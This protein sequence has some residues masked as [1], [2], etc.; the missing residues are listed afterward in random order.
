MLLACLLL[1]RAQAFTQ[2]P[3]EYAFADKVARSLPDTATNTTA[4][5]AGYI[6]SACSTDIDKVRAAY[7]W[8]TANIIYSA[9]SIHYVIMD[10]DNDERVTYALKRK[11]GICENFSA[12]F[13]DICIR[14]GLKAFSIDGFTRQNG[15]MD[16]IP[17][18][19]CAV[20][21]NGKWFLYDPTWD[22]GYGRDDG[23]KYKRG[24]DFFKKD[25]ED[26]TKTHLPFD[27]LFQ[28][29]SYPWS[30]SDFEKGSAPAPSAGTYF[31][32]TDTLQSYEQAAP[33]ARYLSSLSRIRQAGWPL[34][35]TD[36]KIKR[37]RME[38]E[39]IRQDE[40]MDLYNAIVAD[41]N[42][43]ADM[44][45][46]FVEYR[47]SRFLPAKSTEE[48]QRIFGS[49]SAR[50]TAG[51]KKISRLQTSQATLTLDSGDIQKKLEDLQ[52][53][54]RTEKDYYDTYRKSIAGQ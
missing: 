20:Y 8:V 40:D 15:R 38:I 48:V 33:L 34:S 47:N 25:P 37:I 27:P 3:G 11:K 5:I 7:T 32:Y 16:R 51:L 44:M 31:S 52:Q 19:W 53:R 41:Y 26:F 46:R 49:V 23:Y 22:A 10:E 17:H 35:K 42:E 54:V 36:I 6:R 30:Y 12:L 45:N 39:L 50:I 43:A 18:V 9:D 13:T 1:Y 14:S 4:D 28:F 24:T 2:V 21:T 29:L